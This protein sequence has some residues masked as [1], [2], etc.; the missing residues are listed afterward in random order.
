MKFILLSTEDLLLSSGFPQGIV[1]KHNAFP[2]CV[3][4]H[5]KTYLAFR[6]APYHQPNNESTIIIVSSVDGSKWSLEKI[7]AVKDLDVRD[8][9][10]IVYKGALHLYFGLV[11]PNKYGKHSI[12]ISHTILLENNTWSEPQQVYK[13]GYLHARI[14]V[15]NDI[16]YMCIYKWNTINPFTSESRIVISNDGENWSEN[17]PYGKLIQEGTEADCIITEN[18]ELL[19]I[20]RHDFSKKYHVGSSIYLINLDGIILK[21]KSD[22]RKFDSPLL[23]KNRSQL[24]VIAR[25]QASYKGNYDIGPTLTPKILKNIINPTVYWLTKKGTSIW[26]VDERSL[27]ITK[28]ID[29]PS[30]GDTGYCAIVLQLENSI[31]IYNY[32]S[33]IDSKVASWRKSQ[34]LPTTILKYIIRITP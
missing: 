11:K 34:G 32:S 5:N 21:S 4:F 29:L 14:R 31:T 17:T 26:K 24:F 12:G 7:F 30:Q 15:L 25:S 28:Q 16:L 18:Q 20:I 13:N 10:F 23:F 33:P 6:S 8:P 19:W 22:M 2:D 9:K 1:K 3:E 27:S